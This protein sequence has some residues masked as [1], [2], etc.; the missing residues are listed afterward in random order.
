MRAGI[1]IGVASTK[2]FV[3]SLTILN[4]LAI[5][6]GQSRG[7]LDTAKSQE[8]VDGLA[9]LPRLMG[10]LLAD[11]AVYRHLAQEYV[12]FDYFLFLGR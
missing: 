3:A 7:F 8:L 11:S 2:T 6:L 10:D 4:L 9:Q 1:E 12:S 5:F